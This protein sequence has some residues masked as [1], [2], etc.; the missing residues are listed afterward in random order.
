MIKNDDAEDQEE[1]YNEYICDCPK[2]FQANRLTFENISKNP[3]TWILNLSFL[4]Q[5]S[6]SVTEDLLF[7]LNTLNLW[8]LRVYYFVIHPQWISKK[9]Q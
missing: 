1:Y 9:K 4:E 2:D 3:L 6:R 8:Y 7:A 5:H